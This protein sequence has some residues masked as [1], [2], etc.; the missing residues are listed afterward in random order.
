MSKKRPRVAR[1]LI[2][3]TSMKASASKSEPAYWRKRLF[4]NTFTYKGKSV[5]V[6]S[7]S[8]KIQILGHRRTFSLSSSDRAKAAT[9]ACRIYQ[10][11]VT[12]GWRAM[13]QHAKK[14]GDR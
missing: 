11:I 3:G 7:W 14:N 4:K 9:E 10:T 2:V 1:R 8:V 6:S 5:E 13:N 12:Q